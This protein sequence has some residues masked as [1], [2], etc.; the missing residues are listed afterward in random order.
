MM[1]WRYVL[2]QQIPRHG[3]ALHHRLVHG[4][5]VR[6]YLR[7][8]SH[9]RSRRVQNA[10]VNLPPRSRL[11]PV[12]FRVI[13]D[14]VVPF[15]PALQAP[16]DIIPR[17]ARLQSHERVWEIVALE[18]VLGWEVVGLRLSLLSYPRGELVVLMEMMR[19]GAEIVKKLAK[20][21][22]T[23]VSAHRIRAQVVVTGGVDRFLQ[24]DAL[25]IEIDIAEAFVL[26]R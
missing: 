26:R 2:Y 15:I 16:L 10:R 1:I 25:A 12:R 19:D 14:A 24:Q 11:Q 6:V 22:P 23:A 9:Q 17:C 3:A 21:V 7:F 5:D 4:E 20:Q 18:I 8:V 13:E